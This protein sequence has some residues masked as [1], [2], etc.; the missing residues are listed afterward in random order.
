MDET[1]SQVCSMDED[2]SKSVIIDEVSTEESESKCVHK[3]MNK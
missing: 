1:L 2:K 3:N